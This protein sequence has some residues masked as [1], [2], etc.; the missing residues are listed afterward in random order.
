MWGC[1]IYGP[2]EDVKSMVHSI[3]KIVY[4]S[5][6]KLW[7]SCSKSEKYFCTHCNTC[8]CRAPFSSGHCP[9]DLW[10]CS[11]TTFSLQL[12]GN[13]AD[14]T[15][16]LSVRFAGSFFSSV[17]HIQH[18]TIPRQPKSLPMAWTLLAAST[19]L[20]VS[21]C[22]DC[23]VCKEQPSIMAHCRTPKLFGIWC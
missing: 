19:D 3:G 9:S 13:N 11:L 4:Y 10:C 22:E 8:K 16:D 15:L 23:D 7:I 17:Q 14:L 21:V 18:W 5:K 6:F 1:E 2:C 20:P 12:L